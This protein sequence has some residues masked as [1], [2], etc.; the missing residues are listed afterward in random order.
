M[1]AFKKIDLTPAQLARCEEIFTHLATEYLQEGMLLEDPY[2]KGM[3]S[4]RRTAVDTITRDVLTP[5]Q[6]AVLH[7][8]TKPT[9]KP[10]TNPTTKPATAAADSTI[11]SRSFHLL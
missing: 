1:G 5:S 9:T 8:T 4:L 10:A 6:L 2:L 11:R 3:I 7:P